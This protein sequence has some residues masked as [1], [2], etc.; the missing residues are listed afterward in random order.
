MKYTVDI[1]IITY[2]CKSYAVDCINSILE[3]TQDIN[4]GIIVVDNNSSDDTP[5][6]LQEIFPN[7]EII[8]NPENYGYAK[9]VNIG[10]KRSSADYLIISNADVIY[11]ENSI[12]TLIDYMQEYI[13]VGA[14]GPQQFYPDGSWQPSDGDVPGIKAALKDFFL[15]SN[16]GRYLRK[17]FW[18]HFKSAGYPRAAG[19]VDGAVLA[20]PREIFN[21]IGG[22][23]EDYFFYSEEAD[24]CYRLFR[25]YQ[26][27]II[28]PQST[29]T[30][31]RG[32]S[33]GGNH[34]HN[35][36]KLLNKSKLIFLNKHRPKPEKW[37]YIR[38]ELI[39]N[40]YMLIFWKFVNILIK[41]K[42]IANK[43]D[44]YKYA[45]IAWQE[46]IKS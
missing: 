1:I 18:N 19:Y 14:C 46:L 29:V 9:A 39:H 42:N 6:A 31:W 43:I 21:A 37:L 34:T 40:H 20:T 2:N 12:K 36:I 23:D 38:L 15:I 26:L 17:F 25:N 33:S 5:E 22:F 8:I 27:V 44:Y 16:I 45:I 4:A 11:H 41:N 28:N 7:I 10:A 24:Y 32:A 13:K 3:T 30:H 35:S